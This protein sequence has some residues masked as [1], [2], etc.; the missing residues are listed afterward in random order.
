EGREYYPIPRGSYPT[1]TNRS[2]IFSYDRLATF[3]AFAFAEWISPKPLLL[4]A[5][6]DTV[7]LNYSEMTYRKAKEPKELHL[8]K[9]ATHVDL[10]DYRI[11][12]I[13]PKLIEFCRM[14]I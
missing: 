10:L 9:D 12:D 5:G 3:D 11:L 4:I 7:T 1:S 2:A 8:M 14:S 6:D 13:L